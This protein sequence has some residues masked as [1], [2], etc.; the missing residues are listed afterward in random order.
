MSLKYVSK[1]WPKENIGLTL[2]LDGHLTIN[3]EEKVEALNS[4]IAS[5]FNR[6]TRSGA[7]RTSEL[8]DHD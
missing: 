1:S 4:F 3:E 2:G 5:V 8:E 6:N 7:A